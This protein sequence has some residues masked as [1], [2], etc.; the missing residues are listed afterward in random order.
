MN[1]SSQY[2]LAFFWLKA[3]TS[4]FTLRTLLRHYAKQALTPR[5]PV[6]QREI[7]SATQ[8]SKRT[9]GLVSIVSYSRPS[10]MIIASRT[11]FHIERPWGQ[12]LFS[13]V[14]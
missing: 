14:S 6:S 13:I 10:L 3:S 1:K 5:S 2:K 7:G 4:A 11:Q 9:G 8:K 12:R